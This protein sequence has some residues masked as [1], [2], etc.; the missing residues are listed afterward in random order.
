MIDLIEQLLFDND[1]SIGAQIWFLGD[2]ETQSPTVAKIVRADQ[3]GIV[4]LQGS[5]VVATPWHQIE[6]INFGDV[7]ID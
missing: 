6:A 1:G 5:N 2:T 3:T 7:K 4:R